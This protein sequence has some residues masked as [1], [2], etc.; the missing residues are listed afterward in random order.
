[1]DSLTDKCEEKYEDVCK[2]I[3]KLSDWIN[4]GNNKINR[5]LDSICSERANIKSYEQKLEELNM[6]FIIDQIRKKC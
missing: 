5:L 6:V 4:A 3:Q 2:D 1:M